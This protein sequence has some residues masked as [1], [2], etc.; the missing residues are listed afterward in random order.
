MLDSVQ[1]V[2]EAGFHAG[3]FS[4]FDDRC[5]AQPTLTFGALFCQNVSPICTIVHEFSG[6]SLLKAFGSGFSGLHLW[7]VR[8]FELRVFFAGKPAPK[9]ADISRSVDGIAK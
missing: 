1:T 3:Q 9:S 7:H 6:A 8:S 5:L 4:L 2:R